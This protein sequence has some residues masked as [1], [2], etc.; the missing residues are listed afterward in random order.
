MTAIALS[1]VHFEA[2][3]NRT[4]YL[5][6]R[7]SYIDLPALIQALHSHGFTVRLIC[8]P[9]RGYI[10]TV[11]DLVK[12]IAFAKNNRVEQLTFTPITRPDASKDPGVW[13]WTGEHS[14]SA[15]EIESIRGFLFSQ[16]RPIL[17]LVHGAVVFDVEGQNVCL[18]NCLSVQADAPELRNLIFFP[19]GHLR[20]YWQYPG[21]ILL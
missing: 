1:A 6:H 12:M 21:A 5:P 7:D 15:E 17:H 19:D 13:E 4:V 11:D 10:E 16:G 3:K 20:Y 18:N 8:L 2:E 14:L 9:A